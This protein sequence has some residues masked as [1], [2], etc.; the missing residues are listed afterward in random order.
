MAIKIDKDDTSTQYINRELSWIE[1]NRR[2]LQ[3]AQDN[4][5][6]LLERLKFLS[7]S[8]SNFDEF[9]MV[10][11]ASLFYAV[12]DGDRSVCP[13][14][15]I[16]SELLE[17]IHDLYEQF[18]DDQYSLLNTDLVPNLADRGIY[19][20]KP[21]E[22]SNEQLEFVTH[23]FENS[24][25]PL[26]TP[27]RFDD[28]ALEFHPGNHQIHCAYEIEAQGEKQDYITSR[29]AIVSDQE[30]KEKKSPEESKEDKLQGLV[31]IS[32]PKA[33][34]RIIQ[35][36]DEKAGNSYCLVEDLVNYFSAKILTGFQVIESCVFRFT[37]DADFAVDE[38]SDLDLLEAMESVLHKRERSQ[39]IRMMVNSSSQSLIDKL[40][41]RFDVKSDFVL[42]V[43]GPLQLKDF[44]QISFL[45]G[46]EELKYQRW[47]PL[48]NVDLPYDEDIFKNIAKNDV[49]LYHPFH[50]FFPIIKFF[51]HSSR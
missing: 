47:Q 26:L 42:Q 40:V 45:P 31:L 21:S 30:A 3:L 10:R 13:T 28:N 2:V 17:K 44:M 51:N 25:F 36:P 19:Y 8:D 11:V 39:I 18:L 15:Y 38:R 29:P 6:P 33:I 14:G 20:K 1:F 7:I 5:I 9:F 32:I 4:S 48:E 34:P 23:Y 24:L 49:L 50:S 27:V 37:R 16:A 41:E 46:Y 12:E 22:F 35:L 43:E